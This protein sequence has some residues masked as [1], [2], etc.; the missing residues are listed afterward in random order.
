LNDFAIRPMIIRVSRTFQASGYQDLVDQFMIGLNLF[1]LSLLRNLIY[2]SSGCIASVSDQAKNH[3]SIEKRNSAPASRPSPA[4]QP[5]HKIVRYHPGRFGKQFEKVYEAKLCLKDLRTSTSAVLAHR[6]GR[7][8]SRASDFWSQ[9]MFRIQKNH[10][11]KPFL[12][13]KKYI[14]FFLASKMLKF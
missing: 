1:L 7:L 12:T 9:K 10:F 3:C 6:Q 11:Q 13:K 5:K 14:I 2:I 8:L 4:Q